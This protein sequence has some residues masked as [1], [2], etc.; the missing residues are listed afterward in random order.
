MAAASRS[1]TAEMAYDPDRHKV[2]T[3]I[4]FSLLNLFPNSRILH[5]GL[6]WLSIPTGAG[7]ASLMFS[8]YLCLIPSIIFSKYIM[9]WP[10]IFNRKLAIAHPP[11]DFVEE[12]NAAATDAGSATAIK[13]LSARSQMNIQKS[14]GPDSIAPRL[15]RQ[16]S[17]FGP[18]IPGSY[19]LSRIYLLISRWNFYL[20]G[21][22]FIDQ[23]TERYM[24][25]WIRFGE[26]AL[27]QVR[28][29]W[30]DDVVETFGKKHCGGPFNV[31]I[32]GAGYDTRCYRLDI[33]RNV[34]ARLYE[35][36]AIGTQ[37]IKKNALKK[38]NVDS[39]SVHFVSCDF[40]RENW[41]GALES[42]SDF[43]KSL[44]TV[45]IWEGVSYYLDRDIVKA[46]ISEVSKCGNGSCI[47]F[48][49]AHIA[50]FNPTVLKS[51]KSVGEP[52]KFGMDPGNVDDFVK[53][54]DESS[55]GF[56]LQVWDHLRYEE[57]KDRYLAM[58]VGGGHIGYLNDFGGFLL[59]G[60][61]SETLSSV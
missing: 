8:G 12:R 29:C 35:I 31:V 30:L 24:G 43:D 28:T 27:L 14:G 13:T 38:A 40:E 61:G 49:Y 58:Y 1:Y 25:H 60:I 53:D 22:I 3:T 17:L 9:D 26:S 15:M 6:G 42:R 44:P 2:R 11:G 23:L 33:S 16:I 18:G 34:N 50:C 54:C 39:G 32:L 51:T 4:Q 7:I 59:L 10:S 45:F 55:S 52:W 47:G 19:W 21:R 57:L 36:D 41:M 5:N 37:A 56:K 20:T 48:D 46:T